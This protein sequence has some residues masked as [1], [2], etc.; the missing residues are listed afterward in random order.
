MRRRLDTPGSFIILSIF[1]YTAKLQ[2]QIVAVEGKRRNL[3]IDKKLE[4]ADAYK[5]FLREKERKYEGDQG[6]ER[7]QDGIP[8][9]TLH[10]HLLALWAILRFPFLDHSTRPNWRLSDMCVS[11][12]DSDDMCSVNRG[13]K[14]KTKSCSDP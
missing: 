9:A 2:S 10:F 13:R 5:Q 3:D 7:L 6:L 4:I 11:V 1:I 8:P 12:C 14:L